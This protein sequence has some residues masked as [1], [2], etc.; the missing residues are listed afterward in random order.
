MALKTSS[1][2]PLFLELFKVAAL[3]ESYWG[4]SLIT[5]LKDI[6]KYIFSSHKANRKMGAA[7][8]SLSAFVVSWLPYV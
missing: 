4:F 7:G 3:A 5:I 1:S 2:L 6:F 8:E